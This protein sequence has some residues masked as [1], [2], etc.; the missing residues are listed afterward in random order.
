MNK[1]I[2]SKL[3]K[4]SKKYLKNA[5]YLTPSKI[6]LDYYQ[7]SNTNFASAMYIPHDNQYLD[8]LKMVNKDDV[9]IDMGSGDFRF[10]IMLSR[11]VKKVYSVELNPELVSKSLDI[12]KYNLHSNLI[13]I[14]TDWFNFPIPSDVN[15]ITCL[16]N[17]PKIPEEWHKY[18]TIIATTKKIEY[19]ENTFKKK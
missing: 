14:C 12:F 18:K 17:S 15:V 19:L 9:V 11:K 4:F 2:I 1:D 5:E 6:E 7:K 10:P 16:C 8:I 13:I 3:K